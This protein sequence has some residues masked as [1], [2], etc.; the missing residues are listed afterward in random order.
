LQGATL[1]SNTNPPA[2]PAD[3]DSAT[4]I[5]N[6]HPI[7]FWFF[8]WGEFAERFS[9]YGMK[10][11]LPLY[12]TDVL[13]LSGTDAAS[14]QSYFKT[15]CYFLPLA[16]GFIADRLFGKYWTIVGFSLP[17]VLGH[18]ILGIE[19]TTAAYVALALL[20]GGS[21]VIKPN[22][23][24][25][26][27]QTYDLQRPGKEQLRAAAFMW[28]YFAVNVGSVISMVL[29][30]MARDKWGYA[31]AFQIPAWFMVASLGVFAMGKKFYAP[32][33]VERKPMSLA[34]WK[35]NWI[36]LRPLFAVFLL[37]VFFW[38]VYEQNDTIWIYFVKDYVNLQLPWDSAPM[39]ADR[40]QYI[41]PLLVVTLVP[42]FNF[43][44]GKIDPQARYIT[45]TRKMLAGFIF[46]C[47]AATLMQIAGFLST[48]SGEKISLLWYI[49]A[50]ST[51]TIGEILIYGT[52]L[53]L[54]YAAAP[55]RM[56]SFVTAIFLC[57]I[58]AANFINA[59]LVKLY[60]GSLTDPPE[61]RGPLSP[62]AYF[63]LL[64][65][66][67]VVATV[68]YFFVGRNLD[69]HMKSKALEASE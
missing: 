1:S 28:F 18:F 38:M 22:V 60:G 40:L 69:R 67:A 26:M 8:F 4:P 5:S 68:A 44:F 32:E 12:L 43:I 3:G 24:T 51:L 62:S 27:G 15:A 17:Y 20:A 57:T 10:A 48:G 39:S 37:L 35:E 45:G 11:I 42:T 52:G 16:G 56:K 19:S 65:M 34:E 46:V 21:G 64:A 47:M 54:A 13:L 66:I 7:G 6:H 29:L 58:A 30:P 2:L 31:I 41:N 61:K 25:L 53:E 59:Y 14:V 9:F 23:S 50:F 33:V 49:S 36:T 63:S 55:K